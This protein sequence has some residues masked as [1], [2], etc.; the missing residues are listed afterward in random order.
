MMT[1]PDEG[2]TAADAEELA[3]IGYAEAMAELDDILRALDRD[4][5]DVDDLAHQVRRAALLIRHCRQ[6][7]AGARSE[8]EQIVVEL[9][10]LAEPEPG[11]SGSVGPGDPAASG[12]SDET[13]PTGP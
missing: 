10:E 4:A 9:E 3:G 12:D 5:V 6:R 7:I 13:D 8:V 11:G 1:R 2:A